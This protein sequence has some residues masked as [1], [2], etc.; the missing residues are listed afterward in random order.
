MRLTVTALLTLFASQASLSPAFLLPRPHQRSRHLFSVAEETVT[1][2][3]ADAT[4]TENRLDAEKK[5]WEIGPTPFHPEPR[6]LTP[7]L[8]QALLESRHPHESQDELGR[9]VFL[10]TDWRKAWYSYQSPPSNPNLIDNDTGEAF[11]EI[12]EDSIEGTL[13]ED[14]VGTL[15]RN[16]AGKLGVGGERVQHVMDGDGLISQIDIGPYHENK[17]QRRVTFRSKFVQTKGLQKE[18]EA[19]KFMA[20]GVFGTAPRGLTSLFP[21]PKRGV[22]AEPSTPPLLSRVAG[23][24]FDTTL[25]NSANTHVV[26]FGGKLLALFE[27]GLPYALDPT[28]LETIGEDTMGGTLPGKDK[29]AIKMIPELRDKYQ[30]DFMGGAYHTAHPKLCPR[31]GH[32]VGWHYS[33]LLPDSDALELTFNEWSPKDFSLVASKSFQMPNNDLAPHDMGMTENCIVMLVNSLSMNQLPY[34]LGVKGPAASMSMNGRANVYAHVFPRPTASKQF[35]P[36]VVEVPPCFSIHFSHAYEDE[37]TGNLVAFF[38][39]WP[40]SDSKDFLGAWGGFCPDFKV[41]PPTHIWRLEID[42]QT[43]QFV[44]MRVANDCINSCSEHIVCHPNFQTKQA[45]YVYAITS[46]LVGDS[47]APVGYTR[48]C[49]EDGSNRQLQV[50]EYNYEIDAYWFGSRCFTDEPLVVPKQGGNPEDESDAYLLGMV[51]DAVQ[52]R[53]FLS[54]FDLKQDMKKGPVCKIWLQSHIPH[55]LHGCFAADGPGTSSVFC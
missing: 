49:V 38:S 48:H 4:T 3:D 36:F 15:Y 52:Q 27:A 39:G 51:F 8:E 24:A 11:Y 20:R 46:N 25:K 35:E 5:Y 32:L 18:I 45:K 14:L 21:P 19:G 12:S 31:T 7:E 40:P 17:Q 29:L 53:S 16:G 9:G 26:S 44:D 55:G 22:N 28:T 41:I 13:P 34:L 37:T 47:S 33:L 23:N 43:K 30:P 2:S 6:P 50:G 54:I 10:T 1:A 42:P